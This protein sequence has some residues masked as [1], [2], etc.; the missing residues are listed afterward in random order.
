M[1]G[2]GF[3][4]IFAYWWMLLLE[5][6][7]AAG[8]VGI[9]A[10]AAPKL[11]GG[12]PRSLAS[13]RVSMV[14]TALAV[15]L[16]GLGLIVGVGEA[17]ASY[18]GAS[19]GGGMAVGVA[20]FVAALMIGQWL[21]SPYIINALYRTRPPATPL[22]QSLQV[23]LERLA[24]ASG[25]RGVP[26]LRIAE[27]DAPN[28]FAYGS[29]LAGSYVAVTR[30]LLRM[31]PRE[32][33]VAV[34]GHEVGHLKHRDVAWILALS[35]IPLAIYYLGRSLIFA[36][37]AGGGGRREREDA[38]PLLLVALGAALVAAGVLFRFMVA[39]FNRLREYY[40]DAHSALVTGSPRALQRAL[41]RIH[42][43]LTGNPR[44]A[45]ELAA[46]GLASQLFIVAPLIEVSG[47]FFY[48]IDSAV[49]AL[50][51]QEASPLEEVFA[52]HP[53]VPKRL[54]FLD[55]LA[56]RLAQEYAA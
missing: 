7:V 23:E 33:I 41:A 14:L 52:T 43:A 45:S 55:N 24:R 30:G 4:W 37:L 16:G 18:Y 56:R 36:G 50:K 25:L 12:A 20:L 15:F 13:L 40:A 10:L 27:V 31:A 42:L 46:G 32:E 53:P 34:L 21:F 11:V 22:E 6:L 28:A 17:L 1:F 26:R 35:L 51:R 2:L 38:G 54:R 49:E 48:D 9:V 8:A 5:G 3:G 19:A 44:L 47:G 39:H 29:P